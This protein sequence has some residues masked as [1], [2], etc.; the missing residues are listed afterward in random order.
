MAE[1]HN[2]LSLLTVKSGTARAPTDFNKK[3]D[4]SKLK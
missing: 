3:D 4:F 2:D 1:D